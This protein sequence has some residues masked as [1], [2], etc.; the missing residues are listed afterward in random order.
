MKLGFKRKQAKRLRAALTLLLVILF[1]LPVL[2]ELGGAVRP[3]VKV[4]GEEKTWYIK[5]NYT[6]GAY[7]Y[8]EDGVVRY[9][10]PTAG[11]DT[12]V[13]FLR[14]EDGHKVI[15]NKGTGH[16]I[17]LKGH[18]G[19]K[20]EGSFADPVVCLPYEKGDDTFL[21]NTDIGSAQN[22]LSA[23]G[24]YQDF[25][26]H[27]EGVEN[28]QVRGQ[29][30]ENDQLL[31]GNMKWD[32][33]DSE[34]FDV[35]TLTGE[36]FCIVNKEA[37]TF[38][39]T[40]DGVLTEG[41]PK[42]ADDA[43]IWI[44][45]ERADGSKAIRNKKSSWYLTTKGYT[46][47]EGTV[48]LSDNDKDTGSS[49]N[50]KLSPASFLL[51]AGNGQEEYG[52][53]SDSGKVTLQNL[54]EDSSYPSDKMKWSFLPSSEAGE[55]AGDLILEEGVYNLKNSWYSMYLLED[56]GKA[57][58]GNANPQ[59]GAAGWR[60]LYDKTSG[61]TAI[62]NNK[63]GHYLYAGGE[64][65]ELICT[66][67]EVYYWK[68]LR[69]KNQD[70]PQAI[71]FQ[72][73]LNPDRYL[74]MENLTGFAEDTNAVQPT[75]GTPHWEAVM[76]NAG[77][78]DASQ[79]DTSQGD[80][81]QGSNDKE[82]TAPAGYI[83]LQSAQKEGEYLY[84][85]NSGAICYG[86]SDS[87]DASS[88]WEFMEEK[89]AGIYYLKNRKTGHVAV[90]QGNG[91]LKGKE[92]A[93]VTGE[94]GFWRLMER[95][96]GKI[97]VINAYSKVKD[98]LEPYLNIQKDKGY[99]ESS[100][101][102]KE[103]LTSLWLWESAVEETA[104][105]SGEKEEEVPME[106][107]TDTNIYRLSDGKDYLE[108]T[109]LVEYTGGKAQL[110]NS[111]SGEYLY[112]KD[113]LHTGKKKE[114]ISF[115]WT[116]TESLGATWFTEGDKVLKADKI[117]GTVIYPA[118]EAFLS[119]EKSTFAVYAEKD[120][121]YLMKLD[122]MD[123]KKKAALLVNG[124]SEGEISTGKEFTTALY[125][126]MNSIS[127]TVSEGIESL[128]VKESLA[129][130]YRGASNTAF[131]YQ[132]EDTV[133]TGTLLEDNRTYHEIASEASGR[134]AVNLSG[135]GEY[136]KITLEESANSL[137]L[138]YCIPDSED[139]SGR[140][141]TLNL[142][143]N[144]QQIQSTELT[145][146]YSWVYGNYPWTNN[147]EDGEPHHFFDETR[148]MLP[149]TYHKGTVLKL[150]KDAAN[151]ADY[152][153]VDT[154][155]TELV[156]EPKARPE[157]SLSVTDFGAVADDGKDDTESFLAC[158]KEAVK[159]GKEVYIPAGVFQID[160]PTKDYDAGDNSDK[161]RGFVISDDNVVIRGAG[162][163]HTVLKG[164]YAAFFIKASNIALY[165]FTLSGSAVSRRDAIDPSAIETDYNTPSMGNITI[166]NLWIEHYKTG[167]W[168][169]NVDGLYVLGCR[170]VNTFADGINLRRGTVNS[171]IEQCSIRNTGDDGIALWS[172]EYRN[173]NDSIK[174]NTVE[175]PW[176]ANNISV[177]GG[178][179]IEITDN[180]L[181]DTVAMGAGVNIST[182]FKPEAFEGTIT[183]A[184]NTLSRCGSHDLNYN[185]DDG[186][187][188]FN[189][190]KGN[191][192]KAEV[193]IKDNLISD[194]TY[195]G[196][197]FLNGGLVENAIL[198]GNTISRSG[199]YGIEVLEGAGGKAHL[200]NNSIT[201]SM[202]D[203]ISNKAETAFQIISE[204]QK[205]IVKSEEKTDK[206][207]LSIALYAIGSILAAAAVIFIVWRRK[208]KGKRG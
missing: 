208:K 77:Q 52:L 65:G 19:A 90:N 194:S 151:S 159:A 45:E 162:M 56:E 109:Y 53:L 161:N 201:D 191:D 63:T 83:R 58:Y 42:G 22:I 44:I 7:L 144:G 141:E 3:P 108:G 205:N 135:T 124:I 76:V 27:L 155:E 133:Y 130:A 160:T 116:V 179:D 196:I 175:F 9:G 51:N 25:A 165:D 172:S 54:K 169:H 67:E 190:V 147:P 37:G 181:C 95:A 57:V 117:T 55:I 6:Q 64:A 168:T 16:S 123:K 174:Y 195:Q 137:I 18:K 182:N 1:C 101:V 131:H 62:I 138:R 100:L 43:Y 125:K 127:F 72:D 143:A 74:H 152:Y 154:I 105:I 206:K 98:Y 78:K 60:I 164:E 82:V 28:G 31:W 15:E 163:W 93:E 176:L 156:T 10:I 188:W 106:T 81:A 121:D 129:K 142:Y 139:G 33:V 200:I 13:W 126:G 110:Y 34:G 199:T 132:A 166:Q 97:A 91:M 120:G 177:Y 184:R 14:E 198:Q 24:S 140:Q 39:R 46:E 153:I 197:S 189:T 92:E 112:F 50:F 104:D 185:S 48:S 4:L 202:L 180:I 84:E 103:A 66:G 38:L 148:I 150:Q 35:S 2:A 49:W 85:N 145:S 11:D 86:A 69:S 113:G 36:G 186:A 115:D 102:S 146:A 173:E 183:V 128:T 99:A 79:S 203:K 40:D 158:L 118:S 73:V 26:L 94:G 107:F 80:A 5:N 114:D 192:N 47:D 89:E 207:T 178:K 75:W 167:I 187:I 96:D 41:K 30:L 21:W 88:H 20:E 68:L 8:E 23:S 119:K 87:K 134:K 170:I 157:N 193:I 71:I 70:Y 149:E 122:S 61:N 136:I 59:D 12:F 29:L 17:S 111:E 32:F 171:R 204:V